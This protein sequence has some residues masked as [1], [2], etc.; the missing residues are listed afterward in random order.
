MASDGITRCGYLERER[1]YVPLLEMIP[2]GDGPEALG[3]EGMPQP[4]LLS[5]LTRS[6]AIDQI[7]MRFLLCRRTI[8][9]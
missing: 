7:V 6:E 1:Q 2:D 9:K 8:V 3:R 5:E 4:D